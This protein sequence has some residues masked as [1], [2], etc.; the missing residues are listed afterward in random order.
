MTFIL[1]HSAFLFPT[2]YDNN[3][4][5]SYIFDKGG[6]QISSSENMYEDC[7]RPEDMEHEKYFFTRPEFRVAVTSCFSVDE[8]EEYLQNSLPLQKF[9]PIHLRSDKAT[10]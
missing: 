9:I 10:K 1:G 7:L 5:P 3:F 6:L 2:Y 8:Y 4:F